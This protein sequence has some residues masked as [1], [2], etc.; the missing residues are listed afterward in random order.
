MRLWPLPWPKRWREE[1]PPKEEVEEEKPKPLRE[2]LLLFARDLVVAFIIV[3]LV[4]GAM[5]LYTRV[6]P[7]AV[8]VESASMQ[9][10]DT[11][12][13]IGVIDTGD[14]V[15][16]QAVR[17]R[18]DV[19]TYLEGSGSGYSTYSNFGDVIVFHPL[20][21]PLDSTPIIHRPMVYVV[22]NGSGGADVPDLL[23]HPAGSD[24]SGDL[25]GGGPA[26]EPHHLASL[27]LKRVQ[28]WFQGQFAR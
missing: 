15:L 2:S 14:M 9:H 12:S 5:T 22:R 3:A 4:L 25:V 26:A 19:T 13:S 6:W 16:V 11:S 27:T 8:V 21:Y 28:S 10:S 24:W 20:A 23:G 7:P 1:R 18:S 17:Q